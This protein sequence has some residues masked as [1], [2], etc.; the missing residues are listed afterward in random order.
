MFHRLWPEGW[1]EP[2]EHVSLASVNDGVRADLRYSTLRGLV[3]A[4]AAEYGNRV[5]IEDQG[6]QLSYKQVQDSVDRVTHTLRGRGFGR[7]DRVAIFAPNCW[8]WIVAALGVQC[9]AATLVPINTRYKA[10]EIA[11]VL[12]RSGARLIF[13]ERTFL[14]IDTAALLGNERPVVYFDEFA[15]VFGEATFWGDPADAGRA[16]RVGRS[17]PL[18]GDVADLSF[19]SGTTG[20]SKGVPATHAQNL[21]VF[22]D[23]ANIVGLR[24]DD[25]YL[26][27]PPFFH[28][29]GS[30]A[31]W[32]ACFLVGATVIPHALFDA[33]AVAARL[34]ADRITV[35]TGPPALYQALLRIGRP[36]GA[37]LRLAVTG[38]SMIPP[39]LVPRMHA[40]LGFETV[41]TA[42]GLTESTG[43]VTMCRRG[44]PVELITTT[45][46]RAVPGVEVRVVA[47]GRLCGAGDPGEVQVRGYNVMAG[48]EDN[49]EATAATM[50]QGWLRTGDIGVLDEAGNLRITD[51]L[52][53]MYV[54][55]GFNAY[56]AEI[57]QI[58]ATHPSVVEAA[59]VGVPD[60]RLGE[61]GVAFVVA[62]AALSAEELMGWSKE[63][64]A[65][66][67][68]PRRVWLVDSL[69]RNASGKVLKFELRERAC[70]TG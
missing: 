54:V 67:K 17:E 66:F 56:P 52:K 63:R 69:P 14:G 41:L 25:R 24:A 16:G 18:P 1:R 53:D 62:R 37:S 7:G 2:L 32:L 23:W 55:G 60:E 46:G 8:Q 45:S 3:R 65:N 58:L 27:V 9:A 33:D 31:G 57:E 5:A 59:V 30:K 11:D 28:T 36:E 22:G 38:A 20:R 47:G 10:A 15:A 48:Y 51:R 12:S 49:P 13:A 61:V 44:D 40:E 68:V 70:L 39:D 19:T 4:A 50:E 42:Y 29:F 21:R 26:I 6:V 35:L 34:V 64:L 43:V